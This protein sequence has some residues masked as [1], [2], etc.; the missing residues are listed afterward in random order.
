MERKDKCIILFLFII[1]I[2]AAAAIS[3]A[4]QHF[5]YFSSVFILT[6]ITSGLFF[7]YFNDLKN[8][9]IFSTLPIL[10]GAIVLIPI[11]E[12]K[13]FIIHS[14]F[15]LLFIPALLFSFFMYSKK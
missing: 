10:F 5:P 3:N 13:Q 8:H 11:I 6:V 15:L 12:G 14:F 9:L 7:I 4:P 1:G 2:S